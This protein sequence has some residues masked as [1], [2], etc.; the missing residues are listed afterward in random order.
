MDPAKG[1]LVLIIWAQYDVAR[2]LFQ[3]DPTMSWSPKFFHL[4]TS[5][6]DKKIEKM[7]AS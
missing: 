2:T 6:H 4:L 1:R 3:L 7:T 5:E